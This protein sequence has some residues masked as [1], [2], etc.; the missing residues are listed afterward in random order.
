[1]TEIVPIWDEGLGNASYLLDLGDG[2]GLAL[3]PSRDPG[4]YLAAAAHRDLRL[5]FAA[6]TH[7]HADFVSGS[8][9][10]A[11]TGAA[12]VAPAAAGLQFPH[13]G[14]G[15]GDQVHLGGLGL[16][17]LARAL[18]RSLHEQV[19]ALP[20]DL[21]VYPAHGAGS[22]CSAP[23][24]AEPTTT[25]GRER[26]TN[27]LLAA[28]DEDAFVTLLL[29]GLSSYPGY[30]LRLREANRRGPRVYGGEPPRLTPQSPQQVRRLVDEGAELVDALPIAAFAGDWSRATGRSLE[31]S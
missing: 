25:I 31:A 21:P 16:Q 7:L 29:G 17:A 1:M 11:A 6:E 3:D 2:R 24:R 12:V 10:L 9:E 22:Y 4:P 30:F 14:L 23:T 27:L 15:D 8:R 26:A 18:W 19:P 20:D 13:R 28:P 5:A